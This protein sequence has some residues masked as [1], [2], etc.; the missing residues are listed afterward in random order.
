MSERL[1]GMVLFADDVRD[2]VGGK[3]S[4]MGVVGD[5]IEVFGGRTVRQSVLLLVWAPRGDHTVKGTI[6]IENAQEGY[7]QPPA[8]DTVIPDQGT[9]GKTL[10]QMI[11]KLRPIKLG[12]DPVKIVAD[13]MV[14]DMN[15][16]GEVTFEH[17]GSESPE[18]AG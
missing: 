16:H 14:D 17:K 2:E 10:V 13:F 4:F 1:Q 12:T 15:F 18:M 11:A 3:S 8:L 9:D 5:T 6:T 7:K